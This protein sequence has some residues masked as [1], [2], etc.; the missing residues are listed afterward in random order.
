MGER[1]QVIGILC[2]SVLHVVLKSS[3]APHINPHNPRK[4][5]KGKREEGENVITLREKDRP[6]FISEYTPVNN[7]NI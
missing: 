3:L 6:A 7:N 1:S 5:S 2:P 4:K